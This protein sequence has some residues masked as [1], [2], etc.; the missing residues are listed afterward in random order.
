[1]KLV[2]KI[3]GLQVLFLMSFLLIMLLIGEFVWVS[4]Y[5]KLEQDEVNDNGA[6]SLIAWEDEQDILAAL[7]QDFGAWDG[8]YEFAAQPD[9]ASFVV[10]NLSDSA[11][12]NLKLNIAAV[13]GPAGEVRFVKAVNLE[14][15]EE[16]PFPGELKA[17]IS[18]LVAHGL[19]E[20]EDQKSVGGFIISGGKPLLLGMHRIMPSEKNGPSRGVLIFAKYADRELL[21]EL[22]RKTRVPVAFQPSKETTED[23]RSGSGFQTVSNEMV[24]SYQP[25]AD[26][27]GHKHFLISSTSRT[28][29]KQGQ[30]HMSL[31]LTISILFGSIL[32]GIT[33]FTLHRLILF[34]MQRLDEFMK[35]IIAGKDY[36]IRMQVDGSDEI[37][38]VAATANQM[39]AQIQQS[40]GKIEK[41]YES[42]KHEL[43]IRK[44]AEEKLHYNSLHD[45]LTGLW[46]RAYV[47][48][49]VN[50]II[51]R[52]EQ[53][54]A[55]VSCDVDGLKMM[56]DTLGHH[57]GDQLL[58]ETANVLTHVFAPHGIVARMGGDEFIVL[59]PGISTDQILDLCNAAKVMAAKT[60]LY[61][62]GYSLS[63][64]IG[65]SHYCGTDFDRSVFDSLMIQADDQMYRGKLS[66]GQSN[67]HVLVQGMMELLKVRDMMTEGHSHRLQQHAAI[68]GKAVGLTDSAIGDLRLLAQFHDIG[69]IGIS[70][71]ILLK[72][73]KLTS[74]ERKEMERH[75]EIGHRIAQ[76]IGELTPISDLIL[77]HHEWWNGQGYPLGLKG[78]EIPTESRI[79]AIVDAYD[80]MTSDRPYRKAMTKK[81]A[82][83]ELRRF[84]GVQFDPALVEVFVTSVMDKNKL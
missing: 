31:F 60:E 74:A 66:S 46:N 22:S 48:Q 28:I 3:G 63:L 44:Q 79:L 9:D 13:T 7:A 24:Q 52:H 15:K 21:Q 55:V 81:E 2:H 57:A 84:A 56:N 5:N 17:E 50:D 64:S 16:M 40:H 14:S 10:K 49:A 26:L 25:I 68:V 76:S 20:P 65:W 23:S 42:V 34:R 80:A 12:S 27:Y 41:L 82:V 75:A 78:E 69:K 83:A 11:M 33:L 18:R 58:L 47:E 35:A 30:Q 4:S 45:T 77:K 38:T 39:L 54:I 51:Q 37:A 71:T 29:Y 53:Q 8:M 6:R 19:L 59:L 67:R 1:M 36:S 73:G 43:E 61:N 62:L 32:V 72:P 70:D